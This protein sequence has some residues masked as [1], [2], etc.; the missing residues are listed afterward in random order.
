MLKVCDLKA[1]TLIITSTSIT[2]DIIRM[3]LNSVR[4]ITC[5]ELSL[6]RKSYSLVVV[7][8]LDIFLCVGFGSVILE[9]GRMQG[10][11]AGWMYLFA[12]SECGRILSRKLRGTEAAARQTLSSG[13][14]A[15]QGSI[16]A[17]L[18]YPH[19]RQISATSCGFCILY[20]MHFYT[21]EE[22]LIVCIPIII[23]YFLLKSLD[24]TKTSIWDVQISPY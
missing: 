5:M 14:G 8:T 13:L 3:E 1:A 4:V 23:N 20:I 24:P 15:G 11:G 18:S 12:E 17:A 22:D 9:V 19:D 16:R 2:V 10:A 21:N 6:S 7:L